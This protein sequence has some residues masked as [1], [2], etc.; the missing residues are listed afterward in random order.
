MKFGKA[1]SSGETTR[2]RA[3]A[4][5]ELETVVGANSS[6]QGDLRSSGGVR[7]DGDFQG[8]I[9]IAGNLGASVLGGWPRCS[10]GVPV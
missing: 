10:G 6:I 1:Q 9:E 5:A 3:K 4:A 2:T 8:S 7:I